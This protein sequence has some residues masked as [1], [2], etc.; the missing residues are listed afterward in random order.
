MLAFYVDSSACKNIPVRTETNFVHPEATCDFI[1]L[2][3]YFYSEYHRKGIARHRFYPFK[4]IRVY[5][6]LCVPF[7]LIHIIADVTAYYIAVGLFYCH[8]K[9]TVFYIKLFDVSILCL[10]LSKSFIRVFVKKL[11]RM[12]FIQSIVFYNALVWEF[13]PFKVYKVIFR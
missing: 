6:I 1:L 7:Y 9:T 10:W 11:L 4:T 2:G 3:F 12:D 8:S 5:T 13:N